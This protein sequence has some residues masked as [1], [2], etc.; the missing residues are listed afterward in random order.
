MRRLLALGTIAVLLFI[1]CTPGK[2]PATGGPLDP[3]EIFGPVVA[4]QGKLKAFYTGAIVFS[5][6]SEIYSALSA[7][8]LLRITS[9]VE[10][11]GDPVLTPNGTNLYYECHNGDAICTSGVAFPSGKVALLASDLP[12]LGSQPIKSIG[13]PS[14]SPDGTKMLVNG[15][16]SPGGAGVAIYQHDFGTGVTFRVPKTGLLNRDAIWVPGGIV[17]E[18]L[19]P[20]TVL[21]FLATG[22]A[23][24]VTLTEADRDSK[25]PDLSPDGKKILYASRPVGSGNSFD[26][27]TMNLDGTDKLRVNLET[28]NSE[29]EPAWSPD[30]LRIVYA[31]SPS[32]SGDPHDLYLI[33]ADGAGRTLLFVGDGTDERDPDWGELKNFAGV[34]DVTKTEG[35]ACCTTFS[36]KVLIATK[37][38]QPATV[39]F[40]TEDGSASA[41]T[42]YIPR[43]ETLTFQPGE[44]EKTIDIEVVGDTVEETNE[45][46]YVKLSNPTGGIVLAKEKAKALIENDDVA[47]TPSPTP[48]STGAPETTSKI[49]FASDM[50]GP[51]QIFT[52]NTDG[53]GTDQVGTDQGASTLLFPDWS[54][55]GSRIIYNSEVTGNTGPHFEINERPS[56]G[57][58]AFTSLLSA[59]SD[60]RSP[61]YKPGAADKAFAFSSDRDGDYDIY[62]ATPGTS[63]SPK[64]LTNNP[65][66]DL[67]PNFSPDG[68][69][70]VF[71]NGDDIVLL[72][73]D[74]DG[75]PSGDG[76]NLSQ[77]SGAED[78]RVDSN[79]QVSPD[80]TKIAF[81]SV[82]NDGAPDVFVMDLANLT[83][84]QITSSPEPDSDPTWSPDGS[85]LAYVKDVGGGDSEIFVIDAVEGATGVNITNDPAF[86]YQPDWSPP[87]PVPEEEDDAESDPSS[88]VLLLS[89][90]L[91][92]YSLIDVR[93]RR[94]RS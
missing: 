22:T 78:G 55:D 88:S 75:D 53:T 71:T 69:K 80:G 86:D 59:P 11:D 35:N 57:S 84:T 62:Y 46:F 13:S 42:D 26:L 5:S 54:S 25:D 83:R 87:L 32:P 63:G 33:N 28:A 91:I 58:G 8:V 1:G 93:R 66:P 14:I 48:T 9:N 67:L 56:D 61:V 2:R 44:T 90:P 12:A 43:N 23:Q 18:D 74:A 68:A 10:R 94:R 81:D 52:M 85:Q 89:L 64:Q 30:G 17:Y 20:P 36:F 60:D 73:I 16:P 6:E 24:P 77:D 34:I 79:P 29:S 3:G 39:Q 38:D 70:V 51:F 76:I 45:S 47:P 50:E 31:E 41:D 7:V 82:L 4:A 72:D 92:G 49:A 40:T 15:D 19:G 37:S 65:G 21:K 27:W